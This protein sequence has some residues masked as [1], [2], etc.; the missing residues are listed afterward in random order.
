MVHTFV[1]LANLFTK[2]IYQVQFVYAMKDTLMLLVLGS[3]SNAVKNARVAL[4]MRVNALL[5]KRVK[6]SLVMNVN[7]PMGNILMN[8]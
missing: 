4:I 2:G 5:V 8:N 6:C 3:V 1:I 7:V